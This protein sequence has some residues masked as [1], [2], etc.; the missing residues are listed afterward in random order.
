M[1]KHIYRVIF[2]AARGL[3]TAV[4]ETAT[5]SGKG[6]S[7]GTPRRTRLM[8]A[9]AASIDMLSMRHMAFAALCALGMQPV[10][11]EAQVVAAPGSGS[12]PIVGVTANGLP[13]VQIATPNG[14]GVSNNPYTQYNV[15]SQGLIL[16]NSPGNVQTQLGG[17]VTGNPNL[18]AGSARVIVNQVVGGNASQLL[19]Y[20]EV[21]G[22]KAD[23]V[24]ANPAGIYCNGCGFINTS[25]GV[26]TTGTPVFGG[27]GSLDAFHVT[28]GQIQIGPA[29]LNG[30]NVDEVDLIARSVAVNGKLWAGQS[31]NVVTGN[32]DV[33]YGDLGAQ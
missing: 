23:V 30:S 9:A 28:G 4:Q 16:N 2:N 25:R 3:W 1:N 24:I 18:G 7:A 8:R 32:N 22:Q 12:R 29:G 20:S 31:L 21:A 5:G 11:V 27:T 10:L 15:G 14:A 17:Y 33:R 19:G 26:L 13:I 6:R